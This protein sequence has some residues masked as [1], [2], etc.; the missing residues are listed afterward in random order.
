MPQ[1]AL[2]SKAPT[3][4][5]NLQDLAIIAHRFTGPAHPTEPGPDDGRAMLGNLLR[6]TP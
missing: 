3:L 4:D 2:E 5:T 6:Q 1:M